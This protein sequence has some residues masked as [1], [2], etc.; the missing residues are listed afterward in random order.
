MRSNN[1]AL[2]CVF[3]FRHRKKSSFTKN[4]S[5]GQTGNIEKKLPLIESG[6]KCA[7]LWGV[8]WFLFRHRQMSSTLRSATPSVFSSGRRSPSSRSAGTSALSPCDAFPRLLHV[9]KTKQ[10]SLSLCVLRMK[11]WSVLSKGELKWGTATRRTSKNLQVDRSGAWLRCVVLSFSAFFLWV[12][13]PIFFYFFFAESFTLSSNQQR[14]RRVTITVTS[15][16]ALNWESELSTSWVTKRTWCFYLGTKYP[17]LKDATVCQ[18]WAK[19]SKEEKKVTLCI[20]V[21]CVVHNVDK[22]GYN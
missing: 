14:T 18:G 21:S 20:K 11:T 16:E 19:L 1:W 17:E 9:K 6:A 7:N 5:E 22:T 13:L 10:I 3:S 4:F 8:F 2:L 12:S 15:R